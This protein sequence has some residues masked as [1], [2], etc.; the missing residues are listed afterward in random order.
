MI[1]ELFNDERV[2]IDLEPS[3]TNYVLTSGGFDS[4]VLLYCLAKDSEATG[5]PIQPIM[6]T[7]PDSHAPEFCKAQIDLI[8]S[9]VPGVNI[10]EYLAVGDYSVHHSQRTMSGVLELLERDPSAVFWQAITKN[11]PVLLGPDDGTTDY[12]PRRVREPR[13]CMRSPFISLAKSYTIQL[14]N[15]L[16][17]LDALAVTTTS[18][19]RYSNDRRCG[20]CFQCLERSWGFGAMRLIDKGIR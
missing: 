13:A 18:C 10:P 3:V 9:L 15:S 16:G 12:R 6:V 20:C 1:F 14:A 4:A 17:I 8:N 2:S 5:I 11:P 19:T 7:P